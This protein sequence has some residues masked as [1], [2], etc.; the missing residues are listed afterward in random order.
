MCLHL[1][2]FTSGWRGLRCSTLRTGLRSSTWVNTL[3]LP[4]LT[5][6]D[7]KKIGIPLGHR[8][9]LL[10]AIN[11]GGSVA[12]NTDVIRRA[13]PK[14]H[15][16]P[17]RRHVTVLFFSLVGSTAL[18]ECI[19]DEDK[20]EV[21]ADYQRSV[22][23][24][25]RRFD[26]FVAKFMGDGV[27]V[28]FGYPEGHDDDPERAVRAAL[29][30]VA[31]VTGL[32]T[33]VPLQTRVGIATGL[34]EVGD[35]GRPGGT[36]EQAI[37][38]KTPN[39]ARRLHG[40]AEPNTVIIAES[41]R[42]FLDN[43]F[44]LEDLTTR[45]LTRLSGGDMAWSVLRLSTDEGHTEVKRANELVDFVYNPEAIDLLLQCW[46]KVENGQGQVVFLSGEAGSGKTW[47]TSVLQECLAAEPHTRLR[48]FCSPHHAD[49]ALH[50]I[51]DQLERAA[52]FTRDD[53]SQIKLDKLDALLARSLTPR[54]RRGTFRGDVV[55]TTRWQESQNRI[56]PG[57][58]LTKDTGRAHHPSRGISP[59]KPGANDFR[60]RSVD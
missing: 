53:P 41:T 59:T 43:L 37:V 12:P 40:I 38:S 35:L 27:Y 60:G 21:I 26:G 1:A 44:E 24:T 11:R 30:L 9:K 2:T 3:I 51:I 49:S 56:D 22:S 48:Y 8:R 20:H 33:H 50:P 14:T 10:A 58:T 42:R 29:E 54:H 19:G 55:T 16:A 52:G 13:E 57:A 17:E 31:A 45:K 15:E 25:V 7:L 5:D 36:D 18:F 28:Y 34:V 23:E 47:L 32:R 39:L 46:S 6:Q 4:H